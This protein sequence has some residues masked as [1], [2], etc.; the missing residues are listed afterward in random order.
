M[1]QL[2][3]QEAL[4]ILDDNMSNQ[5]LKRHCYALGKALTAY[6]NCYKQIGRD[7]G[8]LTE[9]QWEIIG[10][11]HDSDWE[12]TTNTPE[13]HTLMLL[14]WLKEYDVPDELLDVF[15]SHNNKITKLKEPQTLLE[16]T[17]ECCDELTG[18]I[19]AVALVQPSKKLADITIE[20]ILKKFKQKEFARAVNRSQITQCEE[21]VGLS[22]EQFINVT[23]LAMKENAELLGL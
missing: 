3:L 15:R 8:T 2:T 17:L 16:W 20:S 12:K 4:K 13:K 22:I 21:K 23:L 18:F 7:T 6:Y 10:V 9:E 5:N 19:V 11:L 1:K 14:E